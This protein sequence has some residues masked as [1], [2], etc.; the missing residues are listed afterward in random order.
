M[1][2]SIPGSLTNSNGQIPE[3][4]VMEKKRQRQNQ[5]VRRFLSNRRAAFGI[6]FVVAE[7]IIVV[8]VPAV[9]GLDPLTSDIAAGFNS[10]PSVKH[11]MGTDAAARDLLSR[12]LYGGRVSLLVGI[13]STAINVLIGLP[14]GL[15][16]GYYRGIA[17]FAVMRAADIFM[18]FPSMILILVM[19][20][21]AGPSL[22][23]LIVIMGIMGWTTIARLVY[24]NVLS[25]KNREYV[26]AGRAAGKSNFVLMFTDI[27]PNAFGPVWVILSFRVGGAILTESGLSFLGVG[28]QAPQASWGNIIN[29]AQS[30]P[31]LMF[32]PWMW[33]PPGVLIIL[34]V[35]AFNFI[36]E[37]IRDA[38]DPKMYT[39][40]SRNGLSE[41]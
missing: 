4:N 40:I 1:S 23:T 35:V 37:G 29:A 31:N 34:T 41:A 30:L 14:L 11:L 38:L 3:V 7:I 33:I 20:S 25:I 13:S 21:V 6:F 28:V 8:F 16:A 22:A 24:G 17:E 32:R 2:F 27:L 15:L 10:P 9:F 18:S 36:G 19:V 26:E 12:I 5:A 39:G